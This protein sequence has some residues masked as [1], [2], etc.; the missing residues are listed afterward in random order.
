[1]GATPV[2]AP[3]CERPSEA[4]RALHVCVLLRDDARDQTLREGTAMIATGF[5]FSQQQT[6]GVR[7]TV[8]VPEHATF[9]DLLEAF[10]QFALAAG[11]H[12]ETVRELLDQVG[13]QP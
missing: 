2:A 11:F 13:E 5:E 3:T 6:D 4:L 10:V 7:V 12:P 9:S 8:S 1:M